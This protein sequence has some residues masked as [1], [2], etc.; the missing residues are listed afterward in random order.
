MAQA[1]LAEHEEEARK[2]RGRH[3]GGVG[4][5]GEGGGG[6]GAHYVGGGALG[7]GVQRVQRRQ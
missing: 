6:E 4:L 5:G 1:R 7:V 2:V 3:S